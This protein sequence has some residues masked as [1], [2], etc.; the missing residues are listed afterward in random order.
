ML[1]VFPGR[2]ISPAG[3]LEVFRSSENSPTRVL[4]LFFRG[5]LVQQA[6]FFFSGRSFLNQHACWDF[7]RNKFLAQH[8]VL[9]VCNALI[10]SHK[11]MF[12][13]VFSGTGPEMERNTKAQ[14]PDAKESS[15]TKFKEPSDCGRLERRSIGLTSFPSFFGLWFLV[16]STGIPSCQGCLAFLSS[17]PWIRS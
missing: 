13:N 10:F 16:F 9:D 4:Q 14:R 11:G 7:F 6:V 12:F 8:D 17:P 2:K 15:N 1:G 3:V 5:K